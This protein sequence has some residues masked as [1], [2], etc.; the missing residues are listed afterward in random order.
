MRWA[1]IQDATNTIIETVPH[2]TDNPKPWDNNAPRH[3]DFRWVQ[4]DENTINLHQG[5]LHE[6]LFDG[7][8]FTEAPVWPEFPTVPLARTEMKKRV[9][10]HIRALYREN[11]DDLYAQHYRETVRNAA[12]SAPGSVITDYEDALKADWIR[13]QAEINALTDKK[14]IRD[15]SPVITPTP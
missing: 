12:P 14:A 2:I 10:Q 15:Y 6:W 13:I 7:A 4:Y 11:V 9:K 5:N 3:S 8:N 1:L